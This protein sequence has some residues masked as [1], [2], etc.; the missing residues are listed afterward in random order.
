M[1]PGLLAKGLPRPLRQRSPAIEPDDFFRCPARQRMRRD[2][3][4]DRRQ[5]AAPG[6][7]RMAA[8]ERVSGHRHAVSIPKAGQELTLESS[9]VHTDRTLALAGAAFEAEI[10]DLVHALIRQPGVA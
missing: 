7:R 4:R 10:E 6:R 2:A 8:A 5:T 3:I 1:V 9:H